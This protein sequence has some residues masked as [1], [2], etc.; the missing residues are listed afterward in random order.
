METKR[1]SRL[2]SC[3]EDQ[4]TR[5]IKLIT[6]KISEFM[7][8]PYED[9]QYLKYFSE[10]SPFL[11]IKIEDHVYI[12]YF[13]YVTFREARGDWIMVMCNTHEPCN[14]YLNRA[15]SWKKLVGLKSLETI[16]KLLLL[17][18]RKSIEYKKAIPYIQKYFPT[19]LTSL[20]FNYYG[21]DDIRN[22]IRATIER[23]KYIFT[24]EE[25]RKIETIADYNN[26]Y[27]SAPFIPLFVDH[28]ISV[29]KDEYSELYL[30]FKPL[31][32]LFS[33]ALLQKISIQEALKIWE[34]CLQNKPEFNV[35]PIKRLVIDQY[36]FDI[37]MC[38]FA[39]RYSHFDLI[40]NGRTNALTVICTSHDLNIS[41]GLF[42]YE[43]FSIL[44]PSWHE[45]IL[46]GL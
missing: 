27:Q 39:H 17:M 26:F 3:E 14:D 32:V 21:T 46:S 38:T 36:H 41:V 43:K 15:D 24:S 29:G 4:Q 22:I 33:N 20:I 31:L 9:F 34:K 16:E 23:V 44:N 19:E 25:G 5:I 40:E 35:E 8:I 7:K 6:I 13:K 1:K 2:P 18:E 37:H 11:S 12:F 28:Q 30:R 42:H 45:K 10:K